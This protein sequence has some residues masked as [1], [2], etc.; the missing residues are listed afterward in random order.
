MKTPSFTPFIVSFITVL[1]TTLT[2]QSKP[3]E[4][5]IAP[6]TTNPN[7]R[8][9]DNSAH[10]ALLDLDAKA[11]NQLVVF[12][13]GT[14]L[15]PSGSMDFLRTAAAM[16]FHTIGLAYENEGTVGDACADQD[17]PECSRA[18]RIEIIEGI[19]T[20]TVESIDKANSIAGRLTSLLSYL[21]RNAPE[22]G[23]DQYVDEAGN[24]RWDKTVISGFSQGAGH[25]AMIAKTRVVTRCL[26]F[27]G[28]DWDKEAL[29]PSS[30]TY[31]PG[32]TPPSHWYDFTHLRDLGPRLIKKWEAYG[33]TDL[34][35][36]VFVEEAGGSPFGYSHTLTSDLP[37]GGPDHNNYHK[38]VVVDRMTPR[39]DE[40]A[41][42]YKPVWEYMLSG[43]EKL[44]PLPNLE[45]RM[46]SSEKIELS[47][48]GSGFMLEQSS[49][50]APVTWHS[51]DT[52]LVAAEDDR[53]VVVL[54]RVFPRQ[55][56]RLSDRRAEQ[57]LVSR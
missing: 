15:K 3:I 14:D 39:T 55:F 46:V 5:H 32:K 22:F 19:D 44:D 4:L 45:V 1:G 25:A 36:I 37:T 31:E 54:P 10:L 2:T 6:S 13:P 11:R 33:L 30:W 34:G 28:G 7:I 27:S 21:Q 53:S 24:P 40:G 26:M 56:F 50:L 23:W 12:L 20:T 9:I 48:T 47:W 38:A 35:E 29:S 41:P 49:F 51:I 42:L 8:E 17:D 52:A 43:P 18:V 16:G 57:S